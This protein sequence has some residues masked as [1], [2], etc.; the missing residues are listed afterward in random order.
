M[1][2]PDVIAMPAEELI[3]AGLAHP[4]GVVRAKAASLTRKLAALRQ[5]LA[6]EHAAA[7]HDRLAEVDAYAESLAAER[8]QILTALTGVPGELTL[9]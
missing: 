9:P 3:A 4:R 1:P 6:A 7:L 8:A 5:E 2:L